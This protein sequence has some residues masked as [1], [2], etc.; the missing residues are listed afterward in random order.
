MNSDILMPVQGSSIGTMGRTPRPLRTFALAAAGFAL[1][2]AVLLPQRLV[3]PVGYRT[4]CCESAR[5]MAA[6]IGLCRVGRSGDAVRLADSE[7][8]RA[9]GNTALAG[10]LHYLR[11]GALRLEGRE[12]EAQIDYSLAASLSGADSSPD[13]QLDFKAQS[14][15]FDASNRIARDIVTKHSEDTLTI[16]NACWELTMHPGGDATMAARAMEP[17]A[18]ATDHWGYVDT[19]AWSLFKSGRQQEA[20]QQERRALTLINPINTDELYY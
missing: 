19:Y 1:C 17:I 9:G 13:S 6:I 20:V 18:K 15:D 8:Y 11:G 2:T 16:N 5:G 7:L 12:D 4:S 3:A 14:G 10:E